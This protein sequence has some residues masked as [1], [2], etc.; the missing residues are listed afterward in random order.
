MTTTHRLPTPPQA[1][2]LPPAH[3]CYVTSEEMTPRVRGQNVWNPGE[4]QLRISG[5]WYEVP[6]ET[7]QTAA[8]GPRGV[9]YPS[10]AHSLPPPPRPPARHCH[11]QAP[12]CRVR[13]KEEGPGTRIGMELMRALQGQASMSFSTFCP[14][15]RVCMHL[16]L[17]VRIHSR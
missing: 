4:A 9:K 3:P 11:C 1:H 6:C 10:L 8:G 17:L 7:P 14:Q 15:E 5:V 13:G 12:E 2:R 16:V